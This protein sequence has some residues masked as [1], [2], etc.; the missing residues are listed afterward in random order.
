MLAKET[1]PQVWDNGLVWMWRC[2]KNSY[3]GVRTP[4]G[5]IIRGNQRNHVMMRHSCIEASRRRDMADMSDGYALAGYNSRTM[6]KLKG[7]HDLQKEW[8]TRKW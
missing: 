4:D 6:K 5:K 2:G 3:I 1:A 7:L 8:L